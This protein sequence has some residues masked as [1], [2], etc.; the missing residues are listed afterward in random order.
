[1]CQTTEPQIYKANIDKFEER[2]SSKIIVGDFF[3]NPC[4]IMEMFSGWEIAKEIE[5]LKLT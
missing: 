1:M 2:N 5:N 3:T 4:S